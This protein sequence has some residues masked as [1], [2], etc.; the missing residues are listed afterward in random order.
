MPAHSIQ[1]GHV[2]SQLNAASYQSNQRQHQ[3]TMQQNQQQYQRQQQQLNQNILLSQTAL[4]SFPPGTQQA[5]QFHLYLLQSA[6][7]QQQYSHQMLN[8]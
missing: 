2:I 6:S 1:D 3:R 4:Q 5:Q 7:Q 8:Q